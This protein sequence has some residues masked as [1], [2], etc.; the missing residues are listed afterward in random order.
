MS[1]WEMR[2]LGRPSCLGAETER[3]VWKKDRETGHSKTQIE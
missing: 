2:E 3:S 1:V